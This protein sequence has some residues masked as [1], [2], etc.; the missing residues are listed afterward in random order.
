MAYLIMSAIESTQ[1]LAED[2][3]IVFLCFPPYNFGEGLLRFLPHFT[4]A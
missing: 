1:D 3:R 4:R 2:L